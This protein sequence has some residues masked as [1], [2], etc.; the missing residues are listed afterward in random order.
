MALHAAL[1]IPGGL[2]PPELLVILVLMV[3]FAVPAVLVVA[4]VALLAVRLLGSDDDPE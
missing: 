3:L 1:A 4:V 2:G